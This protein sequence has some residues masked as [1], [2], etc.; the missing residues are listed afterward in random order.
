MSFDELRAAVLALP[1]EERERL[2][3]EVESVAVPEGDPPRWQIEEVEQSEAEYQAD[4]GSARPWEEVYEEL[5]AGH[6]H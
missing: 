4:P 2:I 1:L 6:G 5:K 3:D